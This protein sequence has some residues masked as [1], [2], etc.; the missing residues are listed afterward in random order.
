MT[1]LR[2]LIQTVIALGTNAYLLFPW[3]S[4]IYQG[5]LKA[6]CH[7]GL[8]CYSCPGALLSCPVGAVQNFIASLRYTTPSSIPHL[9]AMVVGYLGFIGTLVGRLPCGWLCPFG[10]IQDL[11]NKVPSRKFNLWPPLRWVKYGVLAVMVI[12][13]PF[14]L[15]DQYG[16]GQPWF[17]KLL[18]PAGTMLGALPLVILKPQLWT[19]LGFYFWNKITILTTIII[20][21]IFISRPF[22]RI[23]CPLGAFYSLFTRMTLV[24]LEFTEGNCVQCRACVK[25]CPTGVVPHE[26]R[27]SRECIMCLKCLDACQFRALSFGLRR[28]LPPPREAQTHPQ[29]PG[30]KNA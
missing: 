1:S 4:V 10:F 2:W 13:M 11:L 16:I 17:C 28:P 5:P 3:G 18:C 14:F 29:I 19:T 23:L 9:G 27:D 15:L 24:Q 20:L 6:V 25:I 12:L 8:N 21:A 30:V 7:P 26:Q 22:C